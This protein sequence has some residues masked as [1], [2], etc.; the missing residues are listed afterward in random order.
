MNTG[1]RIRDIK[2]KDPEPYGD[3][4][5]SNLVKIVLLSVNLY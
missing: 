1:A 3:V 5:V 2:W 4:S